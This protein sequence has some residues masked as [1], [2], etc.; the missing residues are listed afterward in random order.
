MVADPNLAQ[1]GKSKYR[2]RFTEGLLV[3]PGYAGYNKRVEAARQ[4]ICVVSGLTAADSLALVCQ[5][6]CLLSHRLSYAD[7]H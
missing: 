5:L 4:M 7:D 3:W 2:F 1:S 6:R